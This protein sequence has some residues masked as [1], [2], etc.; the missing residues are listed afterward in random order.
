[1]GRTYIVGYAGRRRRKGAEMDMIAYYRVST[2]RQGISGLGLEAQQAVVEFYARQVGGVILGTYTEIE[3]GRKAERP[4]LAR[5][6]A[7]AKERRATLIVAKLD[8]LT[9]NMGFLTQLLASDVE[10]M[11]ADMPSANRFML[12]IMMALAEYESTLISERTK[13]ALG[14]AKARGQLLGSARPG[15]WDGKEEKRLAVLAKNR[16]AQAAKRNGAVWMEL[17]PLALELRAQG[18][19][20]HRLAKHFNAL[21][22]RTPAGKRWGSMQVRRLLARAGAPVSRV[23]P[24]VPNGTA[25]SVSDSAAETG[26][27]KVSESQVRRDLALASTAPGGAVEPPSSFLLG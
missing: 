18:W 12:H 1:M 9:R 25:P 5:A 7:E 22:K 27:E 11:A 23:R 20:Y 24:T 17:A 14:A 13:A 21:G 16:A 2:Q 3:S 10:F 4:E 6:L 15:H 19:G 26:S 8:R